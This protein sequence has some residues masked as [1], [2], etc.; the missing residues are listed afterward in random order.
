MIRFITKFADTDEILQLLPAATH[1]AFDSEFTR[2]KTYNPILSLLQVAISYNGGKKIFIIDCLSGHG[3]SVEQT[4]FVLEK[5]FNCAAIKIIHSCRQDLQIIE[6]FIDKSNLKN[7]KIAD[8][9]I[10]ANLCGIGFNI[11][12][13]ALAQDLIDVKIDKDLQ[14]SNWQQRPLH[15][16]QLRYVVQDVLFLEDLYN[17]L[18][19]RIAEKQRGDWLL[20]E[21]QNF[22]NVI[23]RQD[24]ANLF[25]NFSAAHKNK[26]QI[27]LLQKLVLWREDWARKINIPRQH[28][29]SDD[30]LDKIVAQ[31]NDTDYLLQII[32]SKKYDQQTRRSFFEVMDEVLNGTTAEEIVIKKLPIM[33]LRQKTIYLALQEIVEKNAQ[34]QSLDP[35]FLLPKSQIKDIVIANKFDNI[36]Y[37]WRHQLL[38]DEMQEILL[39]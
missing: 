6:Q 5:I 22:L 33:N 26:K 21:M 11:G 14:N 25:K 18:Q 15:E 2:D 13:S 31:Y 16:N 28:L 34:Q 8:T 29:M 27:I 7:D 36:L 17:G 24:N 32:S 39:N 1:I 30:L 20:E 9:Q 37:G 12:Y 3:L 38:S 23:F 35:R 4:A 19:D 10:M